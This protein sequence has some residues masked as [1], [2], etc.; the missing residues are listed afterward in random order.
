LYE[1]TAKN[2]MLSVMPKPPRRVFLSHT[3]ELR[4]LPEGETFVAAAER[5][6]TRAGDAVVDMTYFG[7]RD[8]VPAEVC[9][10]MVGKADVYVAIVGFRYGSPVRDQRDLPYTELE[11]QAASE[12]GKP[13]LVFLLGD[14]TQGPKDL[15]IGSDHG[16]RQ[17]AFR[18]RLADSELTTATAERAGPKPHFHWPRT[19]D[20]VGS[21]RP[22]RSA[23]WT[24]EPMNVADLGDED[25]SEGRPDPTDLLDHPIPA[26]PGE[27][28]GDHRP[29]QLVARSRRSA[30]A[31]VSCT[32]SA[33]FDLFVAEGRHDLEITAEG[34][35]VAV[36]DID[37]GELSVLDLAD[38][39]DRDAHGLGYVAWPEAPSV[40][41]VR[42]R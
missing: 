28:V 37:A 18:A 10:Q 20:V 8:E 12:G 34:R 26:V 17:E 13:R 11:F 22:S 23:F 6:V 24:G 2:E 15:F 27:P 1:F 40:P 25:R 16:H 19:R 4:Q 29:E 3:S 32:T 14:Q 9:R 38:T 7:A 30:S 42:P 5:A 35:D 41:A 21:A 36:E 31:V 33:D 39:A